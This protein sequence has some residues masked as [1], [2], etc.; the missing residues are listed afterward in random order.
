MSVWAALSRIALL[1]QGSKKDDSSKYQF[2]YQAG[3][4]SVADSSSQLLEEHE[5]EIYKQ[6]IWMKGDYEQQIV[7]VTK[8][9]SWYNIAMLSEIHLSEKDS[10]QKLV[11]DPSSGKVNQSMKNKGGFVG[12]AIYAEL[13]NQLELY[14]LWILCACTFT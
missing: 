10:W 1:T 9:L 14:G 8:E 13:N 3:Q 4:Q 11:W 6:E 5:K 12:F 7:I 2:N